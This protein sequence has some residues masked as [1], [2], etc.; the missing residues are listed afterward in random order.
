MLSD[1]LEEPAVKRN[2]FV[3]GTLASGVAVLSPLGSLPP[4]FQVSMGFFG[5]SMFLA[6]ISLQS[7]QLSWIAKSNFKTLSDPNSQANKA[8]AKVDLKSIEQLCALE[9]SKVEKQLLK[10]LKEN[11]KSIERIVKSF[12]SEFAGAELERGTWGEQLQ[13]EIP[14]EFFAVI[15]FIR[16]LRPD[17]RMLYLGPS[18]SVDK[19]EHWLLEHGFL[20][21]KVLS[22][23]RI[24]PERL[25]V[26]RFST[27]IL[28]LVGLSGRHPVHQLDAGAFSSE[29]QILSIGHAKD[30]SSSVNLVNLNPAVTLRSVPDRDLAY[31]KVIRIWK[32]WK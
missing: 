4:K 28:N 14:D 17:N 7:R 13:R 29:A 23:D 16:G 10:M 2:M 5:T 12:E 11:E 15:P 8:P 25:K 22:W 9:T 6:L 1:V 30:D 3:A 19:I 24:E 21:S 20:K 27:I 31:G 26:E 32:E 18:H